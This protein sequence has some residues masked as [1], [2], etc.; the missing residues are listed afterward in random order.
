M[1]NAEI[2]QSTRASEQEF[3][4]G[5]PR[6]ISELLLHSFPNADYNG[7]Q[8]ADRKVIGRELIGIFEELSP[9]ERAQAMRIRAK[10][11]LFFL[12][13]GILGFTDLTKFTHG[14]FCNFVEDPRYQRKVALMPRGSFKTTISTI[15]R[16]IQMVINNPE[17]RILIANSTQTNASK[18]L[19]LIE[20]LF[21]NNSLLKSLFPELI[22]P[23]IRDVR[24]NSTEM[25]LNRAG[26][27][28][29][30]TVEAIGVGGTAVS[31]HYDVHLKDDL[32]NEDQLV[33]REQ[34]EK[35]IEWVK[36]SESLFTNLV[37]AI[38]V[39][40]ATRWAYYDVISHIMEDRSYKVF[41]KSCWADEAKTKSFFPERFPVEILRQIKERQ[42]P[43][44]FSCQYENNP[45]PAETQLFDVSRIHRWKVL[46]ELMDKLNIDHRARIIIDPALGE[47][48]STSDTAIL[49]SLWGANAERIYAE[50]KALQVHPRE[51]VEIAL[52]MAD[53]YDMMGFQVTIF[54]EAVLFQRVLMPLFEEA[55][56]RRGKF[57]RVEMLKTST[58][59]SKEQ[60][61]EVLDAPVYMGKVWIREGSEGDELIKQFQEYP[62]G[63]KR[64]LLDVAAY[65]EHACPVGV[66]TW[67]R[68]SIQR[69]SD[70]PFLLDNILNELIT[71]HNRGLGFHTHQLRGMQSDYVN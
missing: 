11:D 57:Y 54:F 60:R 45:L 50:T 14:D 31:R 9:E 37:T 41:Q 70:N 13:K 21:L 65:A 20:N 36:Y 4:K 18:F 38:D 2:I 1:Q 6:P 28:T 29:E 69:P 15:A 48:G 61:I 27:Y 16:S 40:T 26:A 58:K 59:R 35:V 71:K 46:D 51:M 22:P 25:E 56:I 7:M 19:L 5:L 47:E 43:L 62:A 34:M 53:K 10:T 12:C 44:I 17:I 67:D 66:K 42:G 8:L 32:V 64:D 68:P 52:A 55:M 49:M 23:K 39:H 24:W 63:K 30:A 3:I 33:S